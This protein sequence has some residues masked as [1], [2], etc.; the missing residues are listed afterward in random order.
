MPFASVLVF[1]YVRTSFEG[2]VAPGFSVHTQPLVSDV[3]LTFVHLCT[4]VIVDAADQTVRTHNDPLQSMFYC[5]A[6][7]QL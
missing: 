4:A 3:P 2:N 5:F 1:S 7:L 6:V